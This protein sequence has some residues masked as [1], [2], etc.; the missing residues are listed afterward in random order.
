VKPGKS[1][2]GALLISLSLSLASLPASSR[3]DGHS[4]VNLVKPG[5]PVRSKIEFINQAAQAFTNKNKQL[6]SMFRSGLTNAVDKQSFEEPDGTVYVQTGDI[7]AEWLRDSSAQV[8]PYLYFAA[9]NATARGYLSRV[10]ARQAAYILS[11]P[12]ANAFKENK[13]IWERKYELDSLCYPIILACTYYKVTGDTSIFTAQFEQAMKAAV[14]IMIIEQN[15]PGDSK[16]THE[17]FKTAWK[18]S[19]V[20]ATGMSWSGFRPS[21]DA[22]RYHFLIPSEMMAVVALRGLEQI[23]SM[24]SKD[25]GKVFAY[26]VDGFG[27]YTLEDDANIP[28]LLSAPYFGYVAANDPVYQNT[29]RLILSRANPNFA[30]G[31]VASGIGSEHTPKGYVWPLAMVMRGLTESKEENIAQILQEIL[32]CDPGDHLLHESFDPNKPT[33]F[34]R[35]DFGW[36]NALFAEL[37]MLKLQN[38]TPLPVLQKIDED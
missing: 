29:R 6:E 16:Y 25:F 2:A 31:K 22:C 8:R 34:T 24:Q 14:T 10:I 12:Y 7:P 30:S 26:E 23:E 1:C 13:A 15:H 38:K 28:S 20:A 35:P 9:S 19:P 37:I 32:A 17:E 27:H 21:D 5:S 33:V 4:R 18:N 36:P 3:D 11:D